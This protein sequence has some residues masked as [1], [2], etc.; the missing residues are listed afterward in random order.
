[1]G[2]TNSRLL[3]Q[4]G[5]AEQGVVQLRAQVRGLREQAEVEREAAR[6]QATYVEGLRGEVTLGREQRRSL[7][8]RI[9][10]LEGERAELLG[11]LEATVGRVQALERK[12]REQEREARQGHREVGEL[13]SSNQYLLERLEQVR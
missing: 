2:E 7:Q 11:S 5:E 12:V 6:E 13:R 10:S 1:M 3:R 4:L 8:T 9:S